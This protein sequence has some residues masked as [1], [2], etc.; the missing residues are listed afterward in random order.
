[1]LA[2]LHQLGEAHPASIAD[3]ADGPA[4]LGRIGSSD[5]SDALAPLLRN[6]LDGLPTGATHGGLSPGRALFLGNR[7]SAVLPSGAAASAPLVLDLAEAAVG[8]ALP[9]AAPEPALR[10]LVSGY[11]AL[12]RL[13]PEERDGLWHA[14]RLASAREGARRL[15]S[16]RKGALQPVEA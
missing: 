1:L 16:G 7:C 4:L 3:P 15:L 5:A 9:L 12:R 14:L 10:A 8:W 2:R 13:G 11:Q 6:K